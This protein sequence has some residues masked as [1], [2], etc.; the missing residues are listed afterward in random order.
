MKRR[1]FIG[2]LG[3]TSLMLLAG[4]LSETLALSNKNTNNEFIFL[5]A[6]QFANFGGWSI[7]QQSMDKMSSP[8]FCY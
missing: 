7:D 6:E 3:N 1:N 5:E 4:G 8:Y 2:A